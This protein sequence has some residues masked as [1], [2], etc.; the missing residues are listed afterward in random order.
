MEIVHDSD[1]ILRLAN[2]PQT[3]VVLGGGV[4]GCEHASIFQALGVQVTLLN[5]DASF[6]TVEIRMLQR[7]PAGI[8]RDHRRH[9]GSRRSCEQLGLK[10]GGR[11]G[12]SVCRRGM[13]MEQGRHETGGDGGPFP[14]RVSTVG[15]TLSERLRPGGRPGGAGGHARRRNGEVRLVVDR[16]SHRMMEP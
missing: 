1:T 13:V 11:R 14:L 10:V 9:A 4:I 5:S 8:H 12:R 3:M 6:T 15:L 2:I 16:E 7:S